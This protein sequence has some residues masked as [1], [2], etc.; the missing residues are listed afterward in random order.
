MQN[1]FSIKNKAGSCFYRAVI[2]TAFITALLL[3]FSFT[4]PLGNSFSALFNAGSP[5][6]LS[7]SRLSGIAFF[8]LKTSLLSTLL[9][10]L[11]GLPCAFLVSRRSFFFKKILESFS[12]VPLCVPSLITALGFITV[13]GANGFVSRTL[14]LLLGKEIRLTFLYTT[15]GVILVQGFYNFPLVMSGVSTVWKNLGRR[16]EESAAVLGSSGIRT[17]LYVTLPKILPSLLSSMIPVF[18][19]CFFSFMI[20]L[21]FSPPGSSTFETEIYRLTRNL[22][23]LKGTAV[24]SALETAAALITVVCYMQAEKKVSIKEDRTFL[25]GENLKKKIRGKETVFSAAVFIPVMFFFVMPLLSI[26]ISSAGT[27]YWKELFK[28]KGFLPAAGATLLLGST[29]AL[30]SV[31]AALLLSIYMRLR[32]RKNTLLKILPVIPMAVSPVILGTGFRRVFPDQSFIFLALAQSSLIW[33]LAF[34]IIQPAAE[35]IPDRVIQG[36]SLLAVSKTQ[37]IF[38][39]MIPYCAP[40][41]LSALALSFAFSAGDSTLPL[42]L[43]PRGFTPLSLFIYRLI[44]GYRFEHACCAGIILA[45][46]CSAVFSVSQR[47]KKQ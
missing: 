22:S 45:A 44:T 16:E 28:M 36:A 38:K 21:L 35:K 10:S 8:T 47:R 13:F 15:W 43:A 9:A 14:S 19:Y 29:T 33:P 46:L 20:V 3:F 41:L 30:L 42:V 37:V 32:N 27:K 34:R 17:F 4:V 40:A 25:S 31:T 18:L 26:V 11:I 5:S 2:L 12:S 23:D 7:F 6:S 24:L 1:S 39:I